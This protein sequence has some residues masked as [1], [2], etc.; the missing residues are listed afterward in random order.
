MRNI[1]TSI[2]LFLPVEMSYEET[3]SGYL[4]SGENLTCWVCLFPYLRSVLEV[5][6]EPL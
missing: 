5:S 2:R 1:R 4:Q 3:G 6:G